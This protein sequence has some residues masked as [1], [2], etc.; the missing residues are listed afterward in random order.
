MNVFAVQ[1]FLTKA[2]S[3]CLYNAALAIMPNLVLPE[4]CT[5]F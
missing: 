1:V 3:K 5:I 2:Y 4:S